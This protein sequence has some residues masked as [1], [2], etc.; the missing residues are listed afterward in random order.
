M[1]AASTRGS[2]PSEASPSREP[3]MFNLD[4]E[5]VKL[6]RPTSLEAT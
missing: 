4:D 3:V 1:E 2:E 5:P 6:A